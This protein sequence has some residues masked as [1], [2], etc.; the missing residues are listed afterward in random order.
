MDA[1]NISGRAGGG[2][3]G[4]D[5]MIGIF[6]RMVS[7]CAGGRRGRRVPEVGRVHLGTSERDDVEIGFKLA[8]VIV[9]TNQRDSTISSEGSNE[10]RPVTGPYMKHM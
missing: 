8:V 5:A 10:P 6:R 9:Q 2:G 4:L 1:K 7:S 3:L